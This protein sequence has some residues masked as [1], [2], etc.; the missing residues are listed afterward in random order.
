MSAT[1]LVCY[2]TKH[3][4]TQEV[5]SA[6]AETL[7]AHG[8]AVD[9]LPAALIDDLAP[10]TGVVVGGAIYMGRWH[11]DALGFLQRHRLALA[12]MPV[13]VFGMGPRTLAEHDV[14]AAREQLMKALAR[15]PEVNPA[16]VAVFGG[17]IDPEVLHFPFNRMPAGDAR[18]WH[19]IR[20]WATEVAEAFA[21]GKA[22]SEA[23][24]PRSELQQS[25]R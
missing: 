13:A 18:D 10:Y 14:E 23:R 17:V 19:A 12:A 7:Q 2:G 20:A 9:T 25:P 24:D 15:V 4:S 22:A 21:Y 5:A 11:P 16:A 1:I 3:G 8:L 6:V